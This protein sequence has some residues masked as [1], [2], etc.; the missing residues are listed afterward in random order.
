[1]KTLS[2]KHGPNEFGESSTI[3]YS[4]E[5]TIGDKASDCVHVMHSDSNECN[6]VTALVL[7]SEN[8]LEALEKAEQLASIASDWNL[9]EVEIDGEMMNIHDVKDIF[10]K[11]INKLKSL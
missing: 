11:A 10:T 2:L 7:G 1:M 5:I 6:R 9:D 8:A 4:S 3:F